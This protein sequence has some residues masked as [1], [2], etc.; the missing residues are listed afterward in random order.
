VNTNVSEEHATSI[1]R[2]EVKTEDGGNMYLR[3]V[4][5]HKPPATRL[6]GVT[7]Q[8]TKILKEVKMNEFRHTTGHVVKGKGKVAL[9]A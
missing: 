6:H 1:F 4:R 3:N 2:Y 9:G 7:T 8:K 5:W